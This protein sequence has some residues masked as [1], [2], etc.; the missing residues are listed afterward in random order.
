VYSIVDC[1]VTITKFI[2]ETVKAIVLYQIISVIQRVQKKWYIFDFLVATS[3]NAKPIFKISSLTD[4][5]RK[6]LCNRDRDFH[7]IWTT[8]SKNSEYVCF[9][10]DLFVFS[11]F[12]PGIYCPVDTYLL[13]ESCKILVF[14]GDSILFSCIQFGQ[15][16]FRGAQ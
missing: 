11:S 8:L 14:M 9:K 15:L 12:H 1:G 7:L 13:R 10:N 5:Q 4:S 2:S 16:R 6:S 3:A